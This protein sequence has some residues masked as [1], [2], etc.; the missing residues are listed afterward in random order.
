MTPNLF[1]SHTTSS[2]QN[3]I[4]NIPKRPRF[5]EVFKV[6]TSQAEH[7]TFSSKHTL[8]SLLWILAS[9]RFFFQG[10]GPKPPLL[11]LSSNNQTKQPP[12]LVTLSLNSCH[13]FLWFLVTIWFLIS[14]N[15]LTD[16][17]LSFPKI[18]LCI[19]RTLM[20]VLV[21]HTIVSY[22]HEHPLTLRSSAVHMACKIALTSFFKNALD[23]YEFS[24]KESDHSAFLWLD[25]VWKQEPRYPLSKPIN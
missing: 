6:K 15:F 13:P 12:S 7:T 2:P 22:A 21:A 1:S 25:W 8:F 19:L 3:P 23:K 11:L 14:S 17:Q 4:A 16:R 9:F 5:L 20:L 10:K 24:W 18:I